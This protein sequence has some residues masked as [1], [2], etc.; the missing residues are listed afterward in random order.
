MRYSFMKIF[1][2][3]YTSIWLKNKII[4]LKTLYTIS[5]NSC[6]NRCQSNK[7]FWCVKHTY[8]FKYLFLLLL[9]S[10]QILWVIC[11]CNQYLLPL[12]FVN[13]WLCSL[14]NI[15]LCD[16]FVSYLQQ[17]QR[18]DPLDIAE[19]TQFITKMLVKYGEFQVK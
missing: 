4:K 10:P 14:I 7:R 6:R 17:S 12:K 2:C 3:T 5:L 1:H 19:Y 13:L 18:F 11:L 15:T 9:K 8:K 16:K